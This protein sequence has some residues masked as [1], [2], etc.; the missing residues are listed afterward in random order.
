MPEEERRYPPVMPVLH[1]VMLWVIR[2]LVKLLTRYHVEGLENV[3]AEGA[4]IFASNHLHHLDAPVVGVSVPRE[5]HALAGERYERHF[6]FG[7]ILK[8]AGS[9]FIRRGEVD[10]R[11]LAQAMAVL[12]DGKT[13]A[14]AVEGTRSKTGTLAEGK[15]GAAYIATRAGVPI[16][17]VVVWGTE[18]IIPS[19]KRLRRAEVVVRFGRPFT[20]PAGRARSQELAAY[21]ARIMAELAAL[22]PESYRGAYAGEV[23]P[24]GT[25]NTPETG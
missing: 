7:P 12:A 18:Q 21:T 20:L 8:I 19:W 23:G 9:I 22:L 15:L 3:P 25:P 17:P 4:L 16:V 14:I 2:L 1:P 13:L 24:E 10:R 5:A 11:A 6:P